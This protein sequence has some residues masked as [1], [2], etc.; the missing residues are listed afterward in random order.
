MRNETQ[1]QRNETMN[2]L[3]LTF[4]VGLTA[5]LIKSLKPIAVRDRR[6]SGDGVTVSV[7]FVGVEDD[8]ENTCNQFGVLYAVE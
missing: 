5:R 4:P 7:R 8:F 3:N 1:T 2:T 6:I